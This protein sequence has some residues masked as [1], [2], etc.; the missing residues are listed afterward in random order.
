MIIVN[1][2]NPKELHEVRRGYGIIQ[3]QETA[4]FEYQVTVWISLIAQI[5][6]LKVAFTL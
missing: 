2:R 1:L 6:V 3:V 4:P 5:G